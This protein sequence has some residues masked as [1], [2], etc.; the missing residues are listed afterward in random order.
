MKRMVLLGMFVLLA[1]GLLCLSGCEETRV[2]K[3]QVAAVLDSLEMKL[4]WTARQMARHRWEQVYTGKADSLEYYRGLWNY[5]VSDP[6]VLS[7]LDEG[8]RLVDEGIQQ[9]RW[10]LAFRAVKRGQVDGNSE[11]ARL[12]RK[13]RNY[14]SKF[15]TVSDE[16]SITSEVLQQKIAT[17]ADPVEREMAYRS[18]AAIGAD[19]ADDV[20][21]LIR[22]RNQ[23]ARRSGF[24][25]YFNLALDQ[26]EIDR[27]QYLDLLDHVDSV[28]SLAYDS[29]IYE[30]HAELGQETIAIWDLDYAHRQVQSD[31]DA[32]LPVDSQLD[33]VSLSL[34]ELGLNLDALPI[35]MDYSPE[36]QMS[37]SYVV[38][39]I[40]PAHDVRAAFNLRDGVGPTGT[41]LGGVGS[42]VFGAF[43]TQ[44]EPLFDRTVPECWVAGIAHVFEQLAVHQDWLTTYANVPASM[45]DEYTDAES[46]H[47]IISLR[48]LL[49]QARFEYEAYQDP[50]RDL[51]KLYWDLFEQILRLPRHDDL[52]PWANEPAFVS[53]PVSIQNDLIGQMIAAQTIAFLKDSYGELVGNATIGAFIT[54]NYLRF[55]SRYPWQE[56][57]QRGTDEPLNPE[58][59]YRD[60]NLL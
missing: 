50:N 9:R 35:Y 49:L 17:S 15:R 56:L 47:R 19:A 14:Y 10:E 52:K 5:V 18:W 21:R 41:Y 58:H 31:L 57:L 34:L 27:Q 29:I 23:I 11:V 45:A 39:T 44:D 40:E 51:N 53:K 60:L 43:V 24:V 28:T 54:Q 1:A 36:K 8:R 16:G 22:M 42:A 2:T 48:K 13:L 7:V 30:L 59:L 33:V 4:D 38:S 32:F 3:A 55:G 12:E 20:A 26:Q 46:R 37:A 25:G 6:Q